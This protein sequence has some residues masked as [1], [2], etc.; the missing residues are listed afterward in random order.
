MIGQ[1]LVNL[2]E[3]LLESEFSEHFEAIKSIYRYSQTYL[4]IFI[5]IQMI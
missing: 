4:E 2:S 1:L 5:S 3:A